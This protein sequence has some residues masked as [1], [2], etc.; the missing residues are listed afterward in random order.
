M[1]GESTSHPVETQ[2]FP[3]TSAVCHMNEC[4]HYSGNEAVEVEKDRQILLH[5]GSMIGG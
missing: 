3:E 2:G 5:I 4:L 1:C